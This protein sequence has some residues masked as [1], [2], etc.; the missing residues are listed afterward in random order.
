MYH[1]T[2]E[3]RAVLRKTVMKSIISSQYDLDDAMLARMQQEGED[4][5]NAKP[6]VVI[7]TYEMIIKDAKYLS[8]CKWGHIIVDEG[9]RLKNMDCKLMQEIKRYRSGS[10]LILTGTPLHVR[11]L[12]ILGV[13]QLMSMTE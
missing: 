13:R 11:E 3:N 1:G 7:T 4:G 6:P 9:H 10:R 8:K 5:G 2:P 12:N